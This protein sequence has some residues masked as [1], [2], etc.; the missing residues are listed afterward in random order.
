MSYPA[1]T[2]LRFPIIF[3]SILVGFGLAFYNRDKFM[4]GLEE[5]RNRLNKEDLEGKQILLEKIEAVRKA[6]MQ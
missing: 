5:E 3:G 6:R 1:G 2:A 4:T